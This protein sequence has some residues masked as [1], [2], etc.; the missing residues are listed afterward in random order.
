[1]ATFTLKGNQVG[2]ALQFNTQGGTTTVEV[3]RVWFAATDTVTI[4][5]APGT[6]DASGAFIGGAGAITSLTVTTATGQVTT[7]FASPDGLDV[8]PDQEKNGADFF[9]I[10]ESPAAG[11]GGAYAGLQLEKL[12]IS[13]VALAA[14]TL[15]TF[16]NTGGYAPGTGPVTP[17]P[18]LIGTAADDT[19]TG[20][21]GADVM[22][23]R[24]GN[25]TIRSLGGNDTVQGGQGNDRVD[26]GG[27]ADRLTGGDGNDR[28]VGAGGNDR[29]RGDAG[30]DVLVGGAG[31]DTLTGGLGGDT[32]VFS[33]GDRVTDFNAAQGDQ[34]A[35][36]AALGLDLADITVTLSAA[37][38]TIAWAGG[39]MLL[40]GVTLP[41]DLGNA[42]DFGY[43]PSFDFV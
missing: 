16:S 35:F 30:N 18:Q 36:D 1:M 29:L 14:G 9:Y 26:G 42:F 15:T 31:T 3:G 8:D 2:E 19:L 24:A 23:G 32:F 20:T 17:Q 43:Q 10:S 34:I 33:A 4:T 41:F 28:L 39:S 7:F 40:Q 37:G 27:G 11:I 38:T 22:D 6:T 13:D 12:L 21:A 25:D 5:T